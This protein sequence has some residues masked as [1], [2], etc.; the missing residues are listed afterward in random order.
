MIEARLLTSDGV[1]VLAVRLGRNVAV[2]Y[3]RLN[4]TLY[5]LVSEPEERVGVF[6]AGAHPQPVKGEQVDVLHIEDK[7]R[8]VIR[9]RIGERA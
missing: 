8:S 5:S 4:A 6:V 7:D 9:W 3:A 2:R 1:Q